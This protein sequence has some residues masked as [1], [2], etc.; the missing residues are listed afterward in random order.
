MI[1]K[2]TKREKLQDLNL[3]SEGKYLPDDFIG[4]KEVEVGLILVVAFEPFAVGF[5]KIE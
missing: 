1:E 5:D 3:K 4:T 2:I